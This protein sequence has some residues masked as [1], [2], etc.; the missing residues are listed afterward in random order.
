MDRVNKRQVFEG[1]KLIFFFLFG[2][3]RE[4]GGGREPPIFLLAIHGVPSSRNSSSE[5]LKFIT[6]SRITRVYQKAGISINIQ[7]MRFGEIKFI[8]FR[9]CFRD[10]LP[11]YYAL[12]GRDFSYFGL[13]PPFRSF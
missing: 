1:K 7:R 4:R 11:F 9:R 5:E 3:G 2:R 8:G 10:L 12:R 6:S 13:F